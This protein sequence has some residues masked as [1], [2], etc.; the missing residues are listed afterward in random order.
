MEKHVEE[1]INAAVKEAYREGFCAG[2]EAV[3]AALEHIDNIAAARVAI[4][5]ATSAIKNVD[6]KD[7][8]ACKE[9]M[10]KKI[11]NHLFPKSSSVD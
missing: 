6:T 11:K 1:K 5:V 9:Y 7:E 2:G 4:L 10:Q 8:I 3:A